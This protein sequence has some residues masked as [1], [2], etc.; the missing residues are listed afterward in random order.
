M[1]FVVILNMRER[2][3]NQLF[4]YSFARN[5]MHLCSDNMLVINDDAII[6]KNNPEQ[7]WINSLDDFSVIPYL[8]ANTDMSAWYQKIFL[9]I[10]WLYTKNKTGFELFRRQK[11]LSGILNK[12][13]L[14]F[15]QD[16]YIP[17]KKPFKFVKNKILVGYF[18][19][20]EYFKDIDYSIRKELKAIKPVLE[21]NISM[22]EAIQSTESICVTVRRGDFLNESISRDRLICT[23]DYYIKGIEFIKEK[24]PNALI[25]FFSDDIDWVKDNIK[26]KGK[27]LYESGNDPVWEKLRLMSSCK[28]FVISNSTFSWWAQHLAEND[29]K[30]VIA[31]ARWCNDERPVGLYEKN[32]TIL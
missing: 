24:Y 2:L 5:I 9:K 15:F 23:V 1:H 14:Y 8:K 7:G 30:I 16:G 3:G 27:T 12:F 25:C 22:L 26:V 29:E 11:V 20:P 28:H 21:K 10:N 32:W 19:S 31:P 18:E 13:G 4:Q 6:K 17:F